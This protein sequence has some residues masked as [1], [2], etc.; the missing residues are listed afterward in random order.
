MNFYNCANAIKNRIRIVRAYFYSKSVCMCVC[1]S[2]NTTRDLFH[3][4]FIS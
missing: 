4:G 3:C 1:V 2:D